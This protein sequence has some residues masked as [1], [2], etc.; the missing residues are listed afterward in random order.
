MCGFGRTNARSELE[1]WTLTGDVRTIV[2]EKGNS[3]LFLMHREH[4]TI[5]TNLSLLETVH[6]SFIKLTSSEAYLVRGSSNKYSLTCLLTKESSHT[7]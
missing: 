3:T 5:L 1:V 4:E 7:F 6:R 2:D